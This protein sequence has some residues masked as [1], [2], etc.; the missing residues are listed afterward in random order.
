MKAKYVLLVLVGLITFGCKKKND[1]KETKTTVLVQ[2]AWKLDAAGLDATNDGVI[3][4]QLPVAIP[5][6]TADNNFT[7]SANGTGIIDEG[8]TKCNASAPQTSPFT[9]NFLSNE[10]VINLQTTALFGLGGQFKIRELSSTAFR[11][12]KDTSFQG[13]PVSIVINLKH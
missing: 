9:W 7:F 6:C 4:S 11:M 1:D 10:T 13:F 12:S 5:A 3:D 2:Q 8:A